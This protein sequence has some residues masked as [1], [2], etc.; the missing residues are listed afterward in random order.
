MAAC[1]EPGGLEPV[2]EGVCLRSDVADAERALRRWGRAQSHFQPPAPARARRGPPLIQLPRACSQRDLISATW[3]TR[4]C[5]SDSR[6]LSRRSI[7]PA[8]TLSAHRERG[9]VEED[10]GSP[11]RLRL[12]EV[13]V[14]VGTDLPANHVAGSRENRDRSADPGG[15]GAAGARGN[16]RRRGGGPGDAA[17]DLRAGPAPRRGE[18]RRLE[19]GRGDHLSPGAGSVHSGGRSRALG[20][21]ERPLSP[22]SLSGLVGARGCT[23]TLKTAR[24]GKEDCQPCEPRTYSPA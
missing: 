8:T 12:R 17:G 1:L 4:V 15:G 5:Q 9:R 24:A 7:H 20:L 21:R 22:L 13:G 23:Q 14:V 16:A 2:H 19:G 6:P 11:L 3:S 10:A 18:G